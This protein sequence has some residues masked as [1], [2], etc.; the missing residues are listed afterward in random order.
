MKNLYL[1]VQVI[2]KLNGSIAM[3]SPIINW[4]FKNLKK[5]YKIISLKL[6]NIFK[7]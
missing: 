4:F 1:Y 3:P 5:I 2:S 6:I 7:D